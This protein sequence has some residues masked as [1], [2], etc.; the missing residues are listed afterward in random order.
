MEKKI[1]SF[2]IVLGH[3]KYPEYKDKADNKPQ[4][5]VIIILRKQLN[6]SISKIKLPQKF[7]STSFFS[8][9]TTPETIHPKQIN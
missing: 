3:L 5:T 9:R 8:F 4:L 6:C 2:G 1:H 7:S